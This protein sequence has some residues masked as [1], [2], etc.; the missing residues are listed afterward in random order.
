MLEDLLPHRERIAK[1]QE[2]LLPNVHWDGARQRVG[3][4]S[5][6]AGDQ[7]HIVSAAPEYLP[8]QRPSIEE[9]DLETVRGSRS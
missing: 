5:A 1:H 6:H 8:S 9:T 4:V 7:P 2:A 3:Y